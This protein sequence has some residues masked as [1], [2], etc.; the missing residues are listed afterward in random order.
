MLSKNLTYDEVLK[1][2]QKDI[3]EKNYPLSEDT[4]A[5]RKNFCELACAICN[6]ISMYYCTSP[7]LSDEATSIY[8]DIKYKPDIFSPKEFIKL[9]YEADN[10]LIGEP[11][12]YKAIISL[13]K[14]MAY[15][16]TFKADEY[17]N[18]FQVELN[19]L[20]NNHQA[21]V[22][23]LANRM[24]EFFEL[25]CLNN[26]N[27][28]DELN[29]LYVLNSKQSDTLPL[30]VYDPVL[31]TIRDNIYKLA[32]EISYYDDDASTDFFHLYNNL[33]RVPEKCPIHSIYDAII[34]NWDCVKS[35]IYTCNII[36]YLI[37]FK[38]NW[39]FTDDEMDDIAEIM[40]SRSH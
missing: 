7:E 39:D 35:Y 27:T 1:K 33:K 12:F 22:I 10:T 16:K 14:I 37:N 19:C 11:E 25:S 18:Y 36:C 2:L 26:K 6:T 5:E 30:E 9:I 17:I 24:I 32:E 15:Y 38:N 31:K 34:K 29:L 23:N 8:F 3:G 21:N 20:K 40:D 28:E 13:C 4:L